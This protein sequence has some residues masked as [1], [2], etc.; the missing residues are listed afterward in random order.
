MPPNETSPSDVHPALHGPCCESLLLTET[1]LFG[2]TKVAASKHRA[3]P[4]ENEGMLD[5]LYSHMQRLHRR[6]VDNDSSCWEQYISHS[7]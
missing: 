2:S 3:Y 7:H 1:L 4:N 6:L 5:V